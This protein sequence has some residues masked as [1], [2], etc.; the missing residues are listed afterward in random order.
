[1]LNPELAL[2]FI[3]GNWYAPKLRIKHERLKNLN[4]FIDR[5]YTLFVL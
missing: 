2:R 3:P 4:L 5:K 1:M